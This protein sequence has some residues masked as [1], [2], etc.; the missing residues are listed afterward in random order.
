[1]THSRFCRFRMFWMSLVFGGAAWAA[2]SMP[3]PEGFTPQWAAQSEQAEAGDHA[4]MVINGLWNFQPGNPE[5]PAT[6]SEVWSWAWVP[7]SWHVRPG[8]NEV[9]VLA[10]GDS[11]LWKAFDKNHREWPLGW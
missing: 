2:D 4:R 3:V 1:M 8:W 5:Q 11:P 6:P 7:G 10:Y 9:G